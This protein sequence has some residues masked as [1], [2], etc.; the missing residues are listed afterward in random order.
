MDEPTFIFRVDS[1]T[2][3]GTGH[4]VRCLALASYLSDLD[5]QVIFICRDHRGSC[6]GM[7]DDQ[8]FKL[9]LL[10]GKEKENISQNPADWLGYSQI[11]DALESSEIILKYPNAHI[12]VDH[13]SL[14]Y[15]WESNIKCDSITVIDDLAN[16]PHKCNLLI[17]QSLKNTKSDYEKLVEGSFGFIGGKNVILREEF[18]K[19]KTWQG[20]NSKKIVICMGG[21]DPYNYT[22]LLLESILSSNKNSL[23]IEKVN[24]IIVIGKIPIKI[25]MSIVLLNKVK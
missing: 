23:D 12:I 8:N 9:Y 6:H 17:D 15:S 7:I 3:I 4:L 20:P 21:T 22:E 1:S 13:Y 18:S 10:D 16:R 5:S 25:L 11:Q 24:E 2:E 14:D 19:A